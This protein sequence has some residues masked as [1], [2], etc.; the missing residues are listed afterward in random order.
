M[1]RTTRSNSSDASSLAITRTMLPMPGFR[2]SSPSAQK[3]YCPEAAGRFSVSLLAPDEPI[4]F[5]ESKDRGTP[6][7]PVGKMN[8]GIDV[9]DLLDR[10]VRFHVEEH[11]EAGGPNPVVGSL[12]PASEA[13]P[14]DAGPACCGIE[15]VTE[16]PHPAV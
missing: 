8:L 16:A 12:Q 9:A 11:L 7:R 10:L 5:G 4:H 1:R 13:R 6:V 3:K 15:A 2:A 14:S